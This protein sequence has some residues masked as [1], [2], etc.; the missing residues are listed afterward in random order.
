MKRY[1]FIL[2]TGLVVLS[3]CK[4]DKVDDT[5]KTTED[6]G[7][8]LIM[9]FDM[10]S[11][12]VRLDNMGDP[13]AVAAGN[14]AQ[15]PIMHYI[16]AHYVEFTPNEYTLLG[17][18]DVVYNSPKTSNEPGQG[19]II[20]DDVKEV[21][22][23]ETFLKIPLKNVN[24]GSYK[25]LRISIAYENYDINYHIDT[26]VT[27]NS[28]D[29]HIVQNNVGR[30]A[31]FLGFNNHIGTYTIKDSSVTV[32]GDETQGYWGFES[33]VNILGTEYG[34][35]VTG[36]V[37]PGQTTVPNVI[38]NTS[39]IPYGSCIVTGDFANGPFV[40]SG[41]ETQDIT[42]RVKVSTN[43]GFEWEDLNGN[44]LYDPL[45]NE[46]PVDMGVRGIQG[47]IE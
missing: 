5:T 3:S 34:F 18:G 11:T 41:N 27:Y 30:I 42:I 9:K 17:D 19:A 43:N 13:V 45:N 24:P 8:Y 12:M 21:K 36:E 32:N 16:A 1:F 37:P 40:V 29:Y 46:H 35:V 44:G 20:I 14:A 4:K 2:M 33:A 26:T 22:D 6:Q 23:G 25:Y 28:T 38:A 10:D 31:N 15:N 47:V 39:P 7:P